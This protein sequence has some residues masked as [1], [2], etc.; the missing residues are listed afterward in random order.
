MGPQQGAAQ[1]PLL[2]P[3]QEACLAI[4]RHQVVVAGPGSG[5]TRVLVER[6][7]RILQQENVGVETILAITFTRKAA[8]EMLE[9]VRDGVHALAQAQPENMRWRQLREDLA[10]ARI[11]T[12]HSFC[13]RLLREFPLEAGVDPDFTVSDEVE[14]AD[15]QAEAVE[16]TLHDIAHAHAGEEFAALDR[17]LDVYDRHDL[18]EMLETLLRNRRIVH[19]FLMRAAQLG[20]AGLLAEMENEHLRSQESAVRQILNPELVKTAKQLLKYKPTNLSDEGYKRVS[21]VRHHIERLSCSLP[22]REAQEIL[23][24]LRATFSNSNGTPCDKSWPGKQSNWDPPEICSEFKQLCLEVASMLFPKDVKLE[25]PLNALDRQSAQILC[26]LALL[27]QHAKEALWNSQGAG[28]RLTFDDLEDRA[29]YLLCESPARDRVLSTLHR[30]FRHILV[31][32][33]QDTSDIQWEILQALWGEPEAP[34]SPRLFVVGDPR[35]AIYGFRGADVR[36]M[37]RACKIQ[38][39]EPRTL[40]ENCRSLSVLMDW[41]NYLFPR[42]MTSTTAEFEVTCEPMRGKRKPPEH[43][44]GRLEILLAQPH[45]DAQPSKETPMDPL[46]LEAHMLAAK[47]V[48]IVQHGSEHRVYRKHDFDLKPLG[49]YCAASWGD[50][51]ILLR[52]RTHLSV[53]EAAL[54]TRGIPYV[55]Y[56]GVGF[57][58]RQEVVDCYNLLRFLVAQSDDIALAGVLRSPLIGL[59]DEGL[60]RLGRGRAGTL[61]EAV[62]R[63]HEDEVFSPADSAALAR[64][65][66]LLPRWQ[67]LTDRVSATDLLREIFDDTG[68]M[69]VIRRGRQG[70]QRVANVDKLLGIIRRVENE[71]LTP[72]PALVQHLQRLYDRE[73]DEGLAQLELEG[74]DAVKIL[75]VHAAKGLEFPIVFLPDLTREFGR[76]E[77]DKLILDADLGVAVRL[78]DTESRRYKPTALY[79]R[80][81]ALKRAKEIAEEKRL[82]YVAVTRARDELY[83]VV[84]AKEKREHNPSWSAWLQQT[85][86]LDKAATTGEVTVQHEGRLLRAPLCTALAQIATPPPASAPVQPL[87]EVIEQVV[88]AES[89]LG[90]LRSRL[91]FCHEFRQYPLFPVTALVDYHRCPAYFYL[92]YVAGLPEHVVTMRPISGQRASA[93]DAARHQDMLIG[94]LVH[95]LLMQFDDLANLSPAAIRR[96]VEAAARRQDEAGFSDKVAAQVTQIVSNFRQTALY[97]ELQCAPERHF[98]LPFVLRLQEGVLTGQIDAVYRRGGRWRVLDY[99]TTRM[100]GDKSKFVALYRPQMEA[101]ALAVAN[102]LAGADGVE[103]CLYL[104]NTQEEIQMTFPPS[105][106]SEIES[107]LNEQLRTMRD[108][109]PASFAPG[110]PQGCNDCPFFPRLCH[111][112]EGPRVDARWRA[113]APAAQDFNLLPSRA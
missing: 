47:I 20:P 36:V 73:V 83:L 8:A 110:R 103:V 67:R 82:L 106:L 22:T 79:Q 1:M 40:S 56:K 72:L 13:E 4:D 49:Q 6:Y 46:A 31:D 60:Y 100:T 37:Q 42:L 29:R 7:L 54:R 35:Q 25:A 17:L 28:R 87:Y 71:G 21:S 19:P 68:F 112:T 24:A 57:F 108:L 99:K 11:G 66:A 18:Q 10:H 62:L 51:A 97:R 65:R 90:E 48:E 33:F 69:A 45:A 14:E 70:K 34:G 52:R 27:F 43:P 12:I 91:E 95:E 92:T 86:A 93:S 53:Y 15:R 55:V 78:P 9:R 80:I 84:R 81:Q 76:D 75:T 102:L 59:S 98:E 16:R 58:Q 64:A 30:R 111:P 113:I 63:V 44:P 39:L 32:E 38:H 26:D 61:W 89:V 94:T 107:R 101:Y 104:P 41:Q 50:I 109:S 77:P 88:P 2:T 96:R 85:L 23:V 5:K 105:G 3:E 74:T